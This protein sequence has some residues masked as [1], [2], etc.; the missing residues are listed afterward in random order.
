MTIMFDEDGD[1]FSAAGFIG[2]EGW[3]T[4]V[5]ASVARYIGGA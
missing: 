1:G 2:E 3:P 5:T 4:V